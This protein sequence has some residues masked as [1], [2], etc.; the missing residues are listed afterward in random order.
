MHDYVQTAI[1]RRNSADRRALSLSQPLVQWPD[2]VLN[3]QAPR[4]GGHFGETGAIPVALHP[5]ARHQA[6][7]W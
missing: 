7:S 2:R 3:H 5:L 1:P 4:P 6:T